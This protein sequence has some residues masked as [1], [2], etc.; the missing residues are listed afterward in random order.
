MTTSAAAS[1]SSTSSTSSISD[2]SFATQAAGASGSSSSSTSSTA[3]A[4]FANTAPALTLP[5]AY[6]RSAT[7]DLGGLRGAISVQAPQGGGRAGTHFRLSELARSE[8]SG[9]TPVRR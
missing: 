7:E 4:V 8:Y 2:T 3:A 5:A 1:S 6:Y 9:P